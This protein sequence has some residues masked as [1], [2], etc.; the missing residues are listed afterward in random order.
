RIAIGIAVAI[1]I[2]MTSEPVRAINGRPFFNRIS[3]ASH[4]GQHGHDTIQQILSLTVFLRA[5]CLANLQYILR[6]SAF[7]RQ[8]TRNF[9]EAASISIACFTVSLSNIQRD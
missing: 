4:L 5:D 9:E 3:P 7:Q 2:P 1:G 6:S 8:T